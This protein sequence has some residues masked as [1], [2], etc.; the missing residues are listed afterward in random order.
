[1]STVEV[2]GHGVGER[3]DLEG[4][5][6]RSPRTAPTRQE[7]ARGESQGDDLDAGDIKER[8]GDD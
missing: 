7:T 6:N 3:S 1:M 5:Q 2:V 8:T 4:S